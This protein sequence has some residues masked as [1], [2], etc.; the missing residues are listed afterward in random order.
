MKIKII[1]RQQLKIKSKEIYGA[2]DRLRQLETNIHNTPNQVNFYNKRNEYSTIFDDKKILEKKILHRE[3]SSSSQY[4]NNSQIH[5]QYS[6][7]SN[8]KMKDNLNNENLN[9][10][11]EF[12]S[13]S[14]NPHRL[15]NQVINFQSHRTPVKTNILP[16]TSSSYGAYYSHNDLSNNFNRNIYY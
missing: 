15:E 12:N 6:Q 2:N 10:Y 16:T 5:N 4:Q 13:S 14:Y 11:N 3:D 9:I 8:L 1:F 7:M